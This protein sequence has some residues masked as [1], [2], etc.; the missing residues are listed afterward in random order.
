[1]HAPNYYTLLPSPVGPL[2]I[3]S[4]GDAITGLY[5]PDHRRYD[6]ARQSLQD[7]E[8]FRE[9]ASQLDAYFA[10]ERT[11]FDLP[12]QPE[13]TVFQQK[14]WRLLQQIP[15]GQTRSYGQLAAAI[16]TPSA[17]RAVGMANGRNPIS[18]IIPC[19]RVIGAGGKL[20][21]YAGGL[22]TKKWLL[23]HECIEN[24]LF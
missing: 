15:H 14:V 19:H 3:T 18:I 20:T 9:A 5:T 10:G 6:E 8:P 16:G 23:N 13:G 12:L 7:A 11:D 1:M 2:V 21:G 17:S 4:N 24:K 22:T